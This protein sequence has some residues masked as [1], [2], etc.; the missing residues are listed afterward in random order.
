M[1]RL[2]WIEARLVNWARWRAMRGGAGGLGY[3]AVRLSAANAGRGGYLSASVPV[4][5]VEAHETDDA[6]R[7]LHPGG[8]RLTVTE[9]YCG[10]G[11]LRDKARRLCCSEGE[12]HR[13]VGQAHT[14]LA[15]HF[16]ARAAAARAES[17]RVERLRSTTAARGF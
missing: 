8:L 2:D 6:V 17:E 3:A 1:A 9:V 4:L 10:A 15:E 12:I 13:R 7:L 16:V 14:Q 5:D 11:G